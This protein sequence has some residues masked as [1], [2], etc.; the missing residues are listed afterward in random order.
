[1]PLATY[2]F[3]K[4]FTDLVGSCIP[5]GSSSHLHLAFWSLSV[6]FYLYLTIYLEF[7]Q[8]TLLWKSSRSSVDWAPTR[9]SGGK[10]FDSCRELNSMCLNCPI[11]DPNSFL[12]TGYL[13]TEMAVDWKLIDPHDRNPGNEECSSSRCQPKESVM[14]KPQWCILIA[15]L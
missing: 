1:M 13:D 3:L 8:M 14:F 4:I 12:T 5:W 10:G 9:C 11:S 7:S 15:V 6:F 2:I